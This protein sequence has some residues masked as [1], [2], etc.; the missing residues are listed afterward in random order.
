ML[1]CQYS[2]GS[3]V[4]APVVFFLGAFVFNIITALEQTGDE[5]TSLALAFGM[6]YMIIP[7]ISIVS[8]LLLAGNNP[9]TLE[10]V[11][12]LE[13]GD[14]E[15]EGEHDFEHKHFGTKIFE[16]AYD[17]RYRPSWIWMRGRSKKAWVERVW[18]TYQ[19]RPA[20]GSQRDMV[21]DEDML[22][23][24]KA[25]TLSVLNWTTIMGLTVL[26]MG[27][28]FVLAF[29]TGFYTPQ[30]GVSCRSLT[31]TV[32][33]TCQFSQL[34][35]W[36]W[37][38]AGVPS[39]EGHFAF[40]R[41]GGWLDRNGFYTPT[42]VSTLWSR[43]T[44]LSWPSLW[45]IIFYNLAAIFGAG[46]IITSLGGT[47]MQ[48]MGVYN[49]D[50]C[51]INAQWW[52]RPHPNVLVIISTNYAEAIRDAVTYWKA[53]AVTATLFLGAVSFC[54]WWYQRR[55]RGMFRELVGNI[56]NPTFD[57]EDIKARRVVRVVDGGGAQVTAP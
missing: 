11:V 40:F 50:K 21:L 4:G 41:K 22:G 16:L 36:V 32:Y 29:L 44:F 55:L 56:G 3:T 26:L 7:H 19:F 20:P 13:V 37:A 27:V 12:G 28:P 35:L 53:F 33:A 43:K 2:F 17:S 23:L 18:K 5:S 1:A 25:T 48:L 8:G 24:R 39:A 38:Y 6:W 9:N 47:T 49:S 14:V 34:V 30:V 15:E 52:T 57:R 46:G 51:D 31:F 10:G 45:A 54:G 42:A